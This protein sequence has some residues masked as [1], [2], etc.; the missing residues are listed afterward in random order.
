MAKATWR[1]PVTLALTLAALAA[2]L[3]FAASA[4]AATGDSIA[5]ADD[6]RPYLGSSVTDSLFVGAPLPTGHYYFRIQLNA[7]QT[8]RTDFKPGSDVLGLHATRLPFKTGDALVGS[9]LVGDVQRLTFKAA[10]TGVYTIDVAA[11]S[12]GTFTASPAITLTTT[13]IAGTDRYATAIAVSKRGFPSS[14]PA[15]VIAYGG[16]YPDALAA[17]PLA[18]AYGGPVLLTGK[19]SMRSDILAEVKRLAPK[20]IFIAGSTASVSAAVQT[21]LKGVP[22]ATITRFSGLDRSDTAAMMADRVKAKLGSVSRVVVVNGYDY[23]DGL[24]AAPLAAAKGWPLILTKGT[25]LPT[26]SSAVLTRLAPSSTLVVGDTTDVSAAVYNLLPGTKTR[27][28]NTDHY[29]QAGAVLDYAKTQAVTVRH[30]ALAKGT[31]FPDA[32]SAGPFLAKDNGLLLMTNP[33]SLP[34]AIS[35]R[36]SG[37]KA[38]IDVLD[39]LG[40]ANSVSDPVVNAAES[41]LR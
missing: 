17:A 40:Q 27:L 21:Q 3:M 25:T 39:V 8:L 18:K 23:H 37:N 9:T 30:I 24:L 29:V 10:A 33:T 32:L 34:T 41:A 15:V 12:G 26:Y 7:G 35:Q 5:N 13:R 19:D 36:F 2:A 4:F 20:E 16:N 6:L 1:L 28:G 14:A 11:S 31:D 22:G 38:T